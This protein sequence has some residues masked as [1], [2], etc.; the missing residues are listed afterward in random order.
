MPKTPARDDYF[1][2]SF[3]FTPEQAAVLK[4]EAVRLGSTTTF[5]R[6]L[7]DDYR[8]LYGL[9][10][11]LTEQLDAEAKSLGKSRREYVIHLL[12]QRGA[13][14]LKGEVLLASKKASGKP[15]R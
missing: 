7:L 9:P 1:A 15:K 5:V 3:R 10:E 12:S 4:E 11:V 13:Q 14:L 6:Q 2:Q 8:T